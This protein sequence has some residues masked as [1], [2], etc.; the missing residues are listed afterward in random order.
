MRQL[1]TSLSRSENV[2]RI[3]RVPG[4]YALHPGDGGSATAALELAT[5]S[6]TTT[7]DAS[8]ARSRHAS[9]ITCR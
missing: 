2:P 8:N 5:K 4:L 6:A 7:A 9:R 3:A 1:Q